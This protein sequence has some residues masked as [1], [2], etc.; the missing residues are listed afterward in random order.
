MRI[1]SCDP[2]SS[3]CTSAFRDG[4]CCRTPQADARRR[5][6]RRASDC[7]RPSVRE[8]D[9]PEHAAAARRACSG[10]LPYTIMVSH[11]AAATAAT[12]ISPSP[13]GVPT[14]TRDDT[15]QF[16]YVKDL[17]TRRGL[18]GGA[19]AGVRASRLVPGAPSPPIASRSIAPTATSR[20]ARRSSSVP[21]DA[22]RGPAR[23]RDQQHRRATREIELTS[24]G[25]VVLAPPDADR[26]HPAFA[27]LFVETEWHEWCSAHHGHASTALG[28]ASGRCG[29]RT[30]SRPD[31]ERVG[32]STCETDRARFVG[33]GRSVRDPVALED[34]GGA[35]RD[36]SAPCSIPIFALRVRVRL[37]PGPV[38]VG[39][40]HDARRTTPRARVRARRPLSRSARRA[41]RARSRVDRDAGGAARARASRRRTR[42]ASR[43][44]PAI[45]SIRTPALRATAEGAAPRIDGSQPRSGRRASPAIG[46]SCWRRSIRRTGCRRCA[47]CSP[48]TT[49][50]DV[51]GMTVD[52]VVLNEQ[53]P[54]LPA[55]AE[56]RRS[57][58]RCSRR[59][60][61]RIIDRPGGVFVRRRDSL[62]DADLAMLRATR[63][64]RRALRRPLAGLDSR[65]RRWRAGRRPVELDAATPGRASGRYTPVAVRRI[66]PPSPSAGT[67]VRSALANRIVDSVRARMTC[68]RVPSAARRQVDETLRFDNGLGGVS[69]DGDYEMRVRGD[70]RPAGAVGER[71]SPTRTAVSSSPS[72]ARGSPGRRTAQFFRLTPWHNDPVSDPVER[73]ALSAGR[74][75][76]RRAGARRRRRWPR[77]QPVH[78]RA[79]RRD[80]S[81]F[82]HERFGIET[83]LTLGHGRGRAGQAVAAA[84]HEPRRTPAPNHRDRVR[85][86][87]L[88]VQREHTQHQVHT[89][90]AP[91]HGAIFARNFFDPQFASGSR[92]RR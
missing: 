10:D 36:R 50:G 74:R 64:T 44:S 62:T 82:R 45:S 63:A 1:R 2:R 67:G 47:S 75:E 14:A 65:G 8:I 77:R 57:P 32:P 70:R 54:Q 23:R 7:E 20:R 76:R 48:R 30:S 18:V 59:A 87:S 53:P 31:A 52:L 33:R 21:H 68:R 61:R 71:R 73:R 58:R 66:R 6:A 46:R 49:T 69:A 90:F 11:A 29:A 37:E 3:C 72:A 35:L 92:S 27:N 25:E 19:P 83:H 56:R 85:R 42:P 5:G 26:A 41:A 88:G 17:T 9:E 60:I 86:W 51:T 28:A 22:R 13:G 12:R 15:G 91:E 78:G 81:S 84:A 34:D 39:R 80:S 89:S 55:G 16:C 79:T 40:V 24:Y 43:S 38:G 4:S